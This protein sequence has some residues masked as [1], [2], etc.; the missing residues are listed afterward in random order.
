MSKKKLSENIAKS[1][2]DKILK[3]TYQSKLPGQQHLADQF[4]VSRVTLSKALDILAAKGLI[5]KVNGHP[6]VINRN[7]FDRYLTL[8]SV[9]YHFG[10]Q[11]KLGNFTSIS[12]HVISFSTRTPTEK[13]RLKLHINEDDLVYDIIRQRLIQNNPFRLEYTIMPV[14]IIPHLTIDVLNDSIYSFIEQ[15]L[16]LKIGKANRVISADIPDAY[17]Q[18]YLNCTHNEPVLRVE[19]VVFLDNGIPFEF[20]ESRARYDKEQ[21]IADNV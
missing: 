15:K 8:D 1:I 9:K 7:C 11:N 2:E 4:N 19:Q 3:G 16:N 12:S 17:D 14:K 20:S 10:L 5:S 18:K 13:E 6:A 21:I